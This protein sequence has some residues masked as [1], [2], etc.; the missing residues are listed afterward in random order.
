MPRLKPNETGWHAS[1]GRRG[2]HANAEEPPTVA[3][4]V[5]PHVA[6][7]SQPTTDERK[8]FSEPKSTVL[9]EF[10]ARA[11]ASLL[12][13]VLFQ[14]LVSLWTEIVSHL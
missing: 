12:G 3:G 11:G 8:S 10:R 5:E 13:R 6:N 1:W 4:T 9:R 14:G 7:M 2:W